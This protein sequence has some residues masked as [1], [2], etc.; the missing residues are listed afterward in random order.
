MRIKNSGAHFYIL[1][2]QIAE[3]RQCSKL[4]LAVNKKQ[5]RPSLPPKTGK[6]AKTGETL[7]PP[8]AHLL[9]TII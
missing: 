4:S 3:C 9:S 2:Y 1:K 8:I 7:L 5:G 6:T